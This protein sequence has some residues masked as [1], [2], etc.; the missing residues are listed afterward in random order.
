[1]A[2]AK[3]NTTMSLSRRSLVAGGA[4]A[5]VPLSAASL[6]AAAQPD[7]IFKAI[8]QH[9]LA[10]RELEENLDKVPRAFDFNR[11]TD[12]RVY[13]QMKRPTDLAC[14]ALIGTVPTTP[15]GVAALLWYVW[16]N[17]EQDL[18]FSCNNVL[19][20]MKRRARRALAPDAFA[21]LQRGISC[22]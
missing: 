10:E 7:P 1:M 14:V 16:R 15:A 9:M 20:I 21:A 5:V 3:P 11:A 18:S 6:P 2:Q 22:G 17:Q 13:R 8:A 4:A 12:Q 19:G